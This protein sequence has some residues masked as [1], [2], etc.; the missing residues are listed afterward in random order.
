MLSELSLIPI[1]SGM[2]HYLEALSVYESKGFSVSGFYPITRNRAL[3]LNEVD[4]MLVNTR[5]F[6]GHSCAGL[7]DSS[8]LRGNCPVDAGCNHTSRPG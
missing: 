4:C 1:Y 6:Q 2:P 3:A 8:H 7:R 5:F